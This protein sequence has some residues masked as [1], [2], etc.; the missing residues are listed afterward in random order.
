MQAPLRSF[1]AQVH[2][3]GVLIFDEPRKRQ[4]VLFNDDYLKTSRFH[5]RGGVLAAG[6]PLSRTVKLDSVC[7]GARAGANLTVD[8]ARIVANVTV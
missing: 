6:K 4:Q 3:S 5:T 7:H 8:N 1:T 2:I